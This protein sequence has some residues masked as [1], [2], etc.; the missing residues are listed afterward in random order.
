MSCAGDKSGVP[1]IKTV[2]WEEEPAVA[3]LALSLLDAVA[4]PLGR[5]LLDAGPLG[6]L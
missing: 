6:P 2:A 4:C 5:R 3:G 1:L